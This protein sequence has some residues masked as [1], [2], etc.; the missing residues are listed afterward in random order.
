VRIPIAAKLSKLK[1]RCKNQSG[2]HL[3]DN[4][5]LVGM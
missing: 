1:I 3:I 2:S 4:M 5:M